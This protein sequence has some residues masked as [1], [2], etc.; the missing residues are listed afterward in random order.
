[1]TP[2]QTLIEAISQRLESFVTEKRIEAAGSGTEAALFV[3]H[4]ATALTGGKRL[5]G[6]FCA[7]GWHAV[8]DRPAAA[9][10]LTHGSDAIGVAAALEVFQ[11]AA[12][13]HDDI[14]DNADT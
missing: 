10:D 2:T 6:R 1:M 9:A 8:A 4:A 11:A 7:T 12:L 13:V 3:E 14:I 5:R